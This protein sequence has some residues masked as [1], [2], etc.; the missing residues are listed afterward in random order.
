MKYYDEDNSGHIHKELEKIVLNWPDV[1]TKLMFGCPAYRADRI[2]FVFV[3]NGRLVITKIDSTQINTL[4]SQFQAVP[5]QAG[6]RTIKKWTKIPADN[7]KDVKALVP[8]LSRSY[9]L[10]RDA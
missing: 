4:K 7:E 5:F 9:A 2:I 10:A 1:T 3:V 8:F 6:K